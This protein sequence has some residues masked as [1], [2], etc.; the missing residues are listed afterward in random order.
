MDQM[1]TKVQELQPET[2]PPAPE[3]TT[4]TEHAVPEEQR[5]IVAAILEQQVR[6]ARGDD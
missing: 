3:N 4:A 5:R 6:A 1:E 2:L